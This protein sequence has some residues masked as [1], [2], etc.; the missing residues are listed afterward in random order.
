MPVPNT[1]LF[2]AATLLL[3][4]CQ[5]KPEQNS[6][7]EAPV[8]EAPTNA[9]PDGMAMPPTGNA[10]TNGT[11][12]GA[13]PSARAIPTPFHG[14][15]GLVPGDCGPDAAIAKGLVT[16]DGEKL[17]FYESVAKPAV[18]TW[19]APDRMEGR[20]AFTG[21]GMEWSKD[22]V[23]QLKDSETLLRTEKDPAATYTYMRCQN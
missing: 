15:W 20:F 18:V 1:R 4:A 3:A 21:E 5:D 22:M 16:I 14:R 2:L 8:T 10:V 7:V 12:S 6:S 13:A 9:A 23:L 17:R 19:P 11:A